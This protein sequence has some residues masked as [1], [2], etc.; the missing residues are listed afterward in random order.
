MTGPENLLIRPMTEGD[1]DAVLALERQSDTAPHWSRDTYRV[2]IET[3]KDSDLKRIARVA[4]VDTEIVGFA[5]IRLVG[6]S[7]GADAE[8]ESIVVSS[9]WR[10]RGL[11]MSLL[12]EV[13]RRAKEKGCSQVDLEVRASNT[14][15]IGFYVRAGF[16]ETGRRRGYYHDRDEDAVL[17][18]VTL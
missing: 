14:A 7:N 15:A 5:V 6:G 4:D 10:G 12:S 1:L 16:R 9:P 11:G 8:L 3:D 2:S 18:S 13:C 17:M